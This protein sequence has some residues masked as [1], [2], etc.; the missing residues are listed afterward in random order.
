[1][2][3]YLVVPVHSLPVIVVSVPSMSSA[4]GQRSGSQS[5]FDSFESSLGGTMPRRA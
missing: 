2:V 3:I 1:M 4:G 5:S